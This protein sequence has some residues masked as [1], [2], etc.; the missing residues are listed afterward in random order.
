M[1]ASRLTRRPEVL[2]YPEPEGCSENGAARAKQLCGF[3]LSK[4]RADERRTFNDADNMRT[5]EGVVCDKDKEVARK[6]FRPDSK[7]LRNAEYLISLIL[8]SKGHRAGRSL[9]TTKRRH[10]S[11]PVQHSVLLLWRPALSLNLLKA[12]GRPVLLLVVVNNSATP[13]SS[14][15]FVL[16]QVA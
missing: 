1:I 6:R 11:A 2:P 15:D 13:S 5:L 4:F 7:N 12:T 14:P 9:V 10:A 16:P 3:R 8:A